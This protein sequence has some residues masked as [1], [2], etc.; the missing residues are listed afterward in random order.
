MDTTGPRLGAILALYAASG[1]QFPKW[2]TNSVAYQLLYQKFPRRQITDATGT[3]AATDTIIEVNRAGA[4]TLTLE[5]ISTTNGGRF[6]IVADISGA[7]AANNIT[8]ARGGSDT[9]N[10]ATSY[11]IN[12]DYGWVMLY[13]GAASNWIVVGGSQGVGSSIIQQ[14][15]VSITNAQMLTLR[16]S[17]ITLVAAPGAGKFLEFISATLFFNRAAA[18]TETADNMAIRYTNGSG[19]IVSE[20]I[21]TTGF[22]DAAGD[23]ITFARPLATPPIL[24]AAGEIA[25]GLLCIHNTGGDEFGG[26]N[27]SNFVKVVT[28]YRVHTTGL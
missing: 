15:T 14:S 8:L 10:G 25:N 26:G 17:P 3:S 20:T 5:T 21:E 12:Q 2:S 6:L 11:V 23:A 16:A 19:T 13:G 1:D 27:A 28:N 24:T 4:V 22:V 9:I 18:Y 7:A